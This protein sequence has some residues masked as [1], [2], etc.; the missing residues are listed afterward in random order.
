MPRLRLV[1]LV[2]LFA[3]PARPQDPPAYVAPKG[4]GPVVEL[5]EDGL[6]PVIPLLS[7]PDGAQQGTAAREDLDVFAG[8]SALRVKQVQKYHPTLPG[9]GYRIVEKPANPGEF[10]YLRFAWRKLGGTGI[11][12]QL[13]E[14]KQTWSV[15]YVAGPNTVGWGAKAVAENA[16]EGWT[17]VSRDL[18]ADFGEL[19]LT[20]IAFTPMDGEGG[21]FDH[22]LLGR[23]EADLD[24]ATDAALGRTKPAKKLTDAERAAYWGDLSNPDP[25]KAAAALRALL[26][27]AAD[28]VAFIRKEAEA[29]ATDEQ[30][31]RVE[32]LI[33]NL[34]S[35][36]F[37][38]REAATAELKRI[39]A[40]AVAA[41]EAV[42][43]TSESAEVK[44]RAADLL[45]GIV[46]RVGSTPTA[47]IRAARAARIL[48][49]AHTAEADQLLEEMARGTYGEFYA[50]G[51]KTAL[52]RR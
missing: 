33:A 47:A 34:D 37:A 6:D 50:E 23:T 42:V 13:H 14:E 18:F 35:D 52:R 3:T 26:A 29:R 17:I 4:D 1:L 36:E 51:A 45:R 28:H 11:M 22:V 38:V 31:R 12:V 20:G 32:Q 15:R 19:K 48:E 44:Y 7:N 9:W 25:A 2:L 46:G 10:R 16:P 24:K 49:Q 41:L 30:T 8:L 5:L 40:A 43:K 39:G 21:L 27:S